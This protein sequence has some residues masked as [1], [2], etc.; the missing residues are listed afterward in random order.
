M[1]GKSLSVWII[2]LQLMTSSVGG[3]WR[4]AIHSTYRKLDKMCMQ[5]SNTINTKRFIEKK[6]SAV[7]GINNDKKLELLIEV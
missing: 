6:K 3:G 7:P 1:F 5:I 2:H 4:G